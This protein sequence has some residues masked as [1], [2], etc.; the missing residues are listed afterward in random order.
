MSAFGLGT[1]KVPTAGFFCFCGEERP[2]LGVDEDSKEGLAVPA[3]D[4]EHRLPAEIHL[5][6]GQE[7]ASRE[8]EGAKVGQFQRRR[9]RHEAGEAF[10]ERGRR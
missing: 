10:A 7:R 3:G 8:K 2:D 5:R 9:R 4:G 1:E 6:L